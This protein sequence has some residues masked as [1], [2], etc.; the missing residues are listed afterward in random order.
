MFLNVR[1][2]VRRY[3][4]TL[5]AKLILPYPWISALASLAITIDMHSLRL[6]KYLILL[7]K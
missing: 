1:Y 7:Q 6:R 2:Q 4:P 3:L 5:M